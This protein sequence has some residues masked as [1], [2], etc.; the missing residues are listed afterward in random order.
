MRSTTRRP[1]ELSTDST[2][3]SA[4]GGGG[5]GPTSIVRQ[6]RSRHT[7]AT[8]GRRAD[9]FCRGAIRH[10]AQVL[11]ASNNIVII[12]IVIV[13]YYHAVRVDVINAERITR[14]KTRRN[15]ENKTPSTQMDGR[16]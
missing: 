15:N 13:V 12:V 8:L 4:L 7:A 6:Q 16:Q 3:R 1:L 14:E 9:P 11:R 5:G 10:C 2:R